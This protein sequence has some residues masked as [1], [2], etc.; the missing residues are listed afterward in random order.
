MSQRSTIHRVERRMLAA[1]SA[2]LPR[3]AHVEV[4]AA[5]GSSVVVR[6]GRRRLALRWVG[7]AGVREVR[8]VLGL[9]DRPD[10]IIGSELSLVARAAAGEAGLGWVDET[11]AAEIDAGNIVVSRS[12][13]PARASTSPKG[14]T[15][16]VLGVAETIL[17][18]TTPTVTATAEATGHSQSSA[19]HALSVLTEMGLLDAEARRGQRSGRRVVDAGRLLEEYAQAAGRV[20]AKAQLQCGVAWRDPLAS[21]K[22]IG[23][24]WDQ[25]GTQWALTGAVGAA[26]LAPYLTDVGSGEVYVEARGQPDLMELARSADIEPID[27]GRLLLRP[28]P[29]AAS[30]RLATRH[31]GLSVAP[32]PRVYADLRLVGVRGEE[33][34]EHLREVMH[35]R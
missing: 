2:V 31:D 4:V 1:L 9:R 18:G 32:W 12:G 15:R 5:D 6:V 13:R 11:G 35:G 24:H 28:F 21:L 7:R 17:C 19:A 26:I 22:R 33:A 16:S 8:D 20:T 27:G 34:A 10:I 30:R 23:L 3:S 29:T 14:W 25:A